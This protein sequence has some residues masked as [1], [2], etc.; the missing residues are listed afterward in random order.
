VAVNAAVAEQAEPGLQGIDTVSVVIEFYPA[1]PKSTLVPTTVLQPSAEAQLRAA[2]IK[3]VARPLPGKGP[4]RDLPPYLHIKIWEVAAGPK[5]VFS[6]H[7]HFV[8]KVLLPEVGN[9]VVSAAT[10][11]KS[12]VMVA[13]ADQPK[14]VQRLEREVRRLV[15]DF[16]SAWRPVN[17]LDLN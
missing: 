11:D 10:W 8:R 1:S 4:V 17:E 5:V 6:F 16:L 14:T 9:A 15:G 2:G 13:P 12:R 3:V 7:A